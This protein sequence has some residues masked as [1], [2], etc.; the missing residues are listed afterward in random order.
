[1]SSATTGLGFT[2]WDEKIS[3]TNVLNRVLMKASTQF[4][5]GDACVMASGILT[6][7]TAAQL[8]TYIFQ[9]MITPSTAL[10]PATANLSTTLG[11]SALC[12]IASPELKFYTPLVANSAP[13]FNGTACN[14]NSTVT[15][16][17]FTGA[18]STNDFV[19]G[20]VWIDNLQQQRVITA[21]SVS[22]GVHTFTVTPAFSRAPTTGD[23][24]RAVPWSRGATA[25]KLAATV[26]Y[27]GISTA[28]ADVSGGHVN[29][30][31]VVLGTIY[32]GPDGGNTVRQGGYIPYAIVSFS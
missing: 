26:P 12:V 27:Q 9:V 19:G 17:V 23:T 28:V 4:Y 16:V 1:M 11:E 3:T 24:L 29:I 18:G 14:S 7:A 8:P 10:R 6:Q 20:Q 2:V 31:A 5:A 21:D 32:D 22:G 30:E 13:T 25:V 15:S